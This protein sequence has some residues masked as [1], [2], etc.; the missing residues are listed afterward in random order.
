MGSKLHYRHNHGF[1][2]RNIIVISTKNFDWA[3]PQLYD[4]LFFIVPSMQCFAQFLLHIAWI[5]LAVSRVQ[6]FSWYLS[7]L[8]FVHS[9][10][11]TVETW[12]FYLHAWLNL[13]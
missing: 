8:L 4:C 1:V 10:T 7:Y 5:Y 12:L 2:W 13:I 6:S 9:K 3:T 11:I